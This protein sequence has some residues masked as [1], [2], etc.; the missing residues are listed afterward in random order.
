M[1]LNNPHVFRQGRTNESIC[2]PFT[3]IELLVVIAI[4]AILAAMLLP[5][6]G[7][8]REKARGVNC[9]NQL[10]QIGLADLSYASDNSDYIASGFVKDGEEQSHWGRMYNTDPA[11]RLFRQGYLGGTASDNSDTNFKRQEKFF[12]CPSDAFNWGGS[13]QGYSYYAYFAPEKRLKNGAISKNSLIKQSSWY[14]LWCARNR[15][16]RHDPGA[17]IFCDYT[18]GIGLY[19]K[20]GSNHPDSMNVLHLG[21]HVRTVKEASTKRASPNQSIL[22][23]TDAL[24]LS[25]WIDDISGI[26]PR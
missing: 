23:T 11:S 9:I 3:L 4:I 13:L 6:L 7:R 20:K 16:G 15:I 14:N 1:S 19:T 12:R 18:E 2:S 10:K 21:G 24:H 22:K 17:A 8:A 26:T 25:R 5:A